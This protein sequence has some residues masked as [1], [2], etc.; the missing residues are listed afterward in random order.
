MPPAHE[1]V[2][3]W[4]RKRIEFLVAKTAHDY[5]KLGELVPTT[6]DSMAKIDLQKDG[7]YLI[8]SEG[9]ATHVFPSVKLDG[10]VLTAG[11]KKLP[12]CHVWE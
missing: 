9:T 5:K 12:C 7:Q 10:V 3:H 4:I 11:N 8:Y 6:G 2:H 1:S